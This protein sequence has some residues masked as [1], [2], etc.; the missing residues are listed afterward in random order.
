MP[1]SNLSPRIT[2]LFSRLRGKIRSYVWIQGIA[3]AIIWLI[4]TFWISLAI[5]YLPVKLGANEMPVVARA[6]LLVIV[7]LIL[8]FILYWWVLRRAFVSLQP[9]NLAVL[10]ERSYP[11]FE[12][13]LVTTVELANASPEETELPSDLQQSMLREAHDKAVRH[14]DNVKL[15]KVFNYNPLRRALG[16]AAIAVASI[17]L[18]AVVS[19]P[20]LKMWANRI[21]GLSPDPY[22]RMT[23]L[24]LDEFADGQLTVARGSNVT[25]RVRSDATRKTP[26]PEVCT[27]Y[28]NTQNGERGRAN[29]SK[30]GTPRDGFQ[31][32]V[33]DGKPFKG[34]LGNIDFDIVG[35]DQRIRD[36]RVR[37]VDSPQIAA[38]TIDCERPA[39]T[40]LSKTQLEYYPGVRIPEGSR[41]SLQLKTNKPIVEATWQ[42]NKD[43]APVTLK[44][45]GTTPTRSTSSS[46]NLTSRFRKKLHC[47]MRTESK[48]NDRIESRSPPFLTKLPPFSCD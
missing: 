24:E 23:H 14:I 26:P 28:Y 2:N 39:Y 11:E 13:S 36:Q 5:D 47:S 18:T 35:N 46:K 44:P 43:A 19:L 45:T 21:Y 34:I 29:M 10:V 40:Q 41:L 9:R 30:K 7:S 27:I 42:E 48:V 20:S 31:N 3:L 4:A 33:F 32:Y 15:G 37:V 6:I 38:I 12:D 1:K 25:L 16:L 8:L 17:I 22:P